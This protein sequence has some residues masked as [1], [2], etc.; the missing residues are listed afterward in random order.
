MH[1]CLILLTA[2]VSYRFYIVICYSV[3]LGGLI[4]L[5]PNIYFAICSFRRND[6]STGSTILRNFYK[7]EAGKFL[8]SSIGFA[9]AF[10]LVSPINGL[11]LFATY[12]GL[13]LFQWAVIIRLGF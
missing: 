12:I 6:E 8:L 3:L 4:F 13:T 2:I 7:G 10:T 11:A 1:L 9:V 5:V